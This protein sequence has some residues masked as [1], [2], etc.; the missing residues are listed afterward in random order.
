MAANQPGEIRQTIVI[1]ITAYDYI[2]YIIK[3]RNENTVTVGIVTL[4][5][6]YLSDIKEKKNL[7]LP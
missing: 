7:M 5:G 1:R 6:N 4:S 2:L 3:P